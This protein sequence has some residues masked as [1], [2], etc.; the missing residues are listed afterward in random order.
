MYSF[1]QIYLE[2]YV[3]C[4]PSRLRNLVQQL[5]SSKLP[6]LVRNRVMQGVRSDVSPESVQTNLG[7]SGLRASN[8]KDTRCYPQTGV[9]CRDLDTCN[10]LSS[11]SSLLCGELCSGR[12]VSRVL[13]HIVNLFASLIGQR[14][15]STKMSQEVAIRRQNVEFIFRLVLILDRNRISNRILSAGLM[16]LRLHQRAKP[17]C[18]F[19]YMRKQ[20]LVHPT[21]CRY[22]SC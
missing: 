9:S 21:R 4:V 10:P 5:I 14:R 19:W 15:G 2:D 12:R 1:G 13:V 11:L 22:R 3:S 20:S 18:S 8:L 16:D 7:P 17:G 6:V